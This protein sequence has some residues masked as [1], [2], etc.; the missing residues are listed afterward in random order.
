MIRTRNLD[1][2]VVD[3]SVVGT[4]SAATN[5]RCFVI[6]FACQLKAIYTKLGTAG[7]TGNQDI[8]INKNDTSIVSSANK[9]RFASA[10]QDP[11]AAS[12]TFTTDPTIFAKGDIV[13]VDVDAVHTTPAVNLCLI[14]V[15][16]R[17]RSAAKVSKTVIDGIGP[18]AE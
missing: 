11:T 9:I 17:V 5:K 3:L 2:I 15:F 16:Q 1:E 8:D 6:P 4:Q 18:E 7:T 12:I 10:A 14:L 13:T